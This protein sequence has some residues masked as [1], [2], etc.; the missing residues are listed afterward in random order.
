M[1]APH[2]DDESLGCG[3]TLARLPDK[4]QIHVIY[5]T[6]GSRAY[7]PV[8]PWL[9]GE[10]LDLPAIRMKEALAAAQAL[11]IPGENVHFLG[12]PDG[13][14]WSCTEQLAARLREI[15]ALI[16]PDQLMMP[17]RYDRHPDHLTVNEVARAVWRTSGLSTELFEYFV[18]YRWRLLPTG[19]VRAYIRPEHL[20]KVTID[21]GAARKQAA[22]DCYRSQTTRIYPWQ[23]RPILSR[24]VLAEACLGPEFFVKFDPTVPGPRIFRDSAAWIRLVHSLEPFLKQ[25][26]D[27][28]RALWRRV[29]LPHASDAV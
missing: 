8:L 28:A 13:Q 25:R 18:Y 14:L 27:R 23:D 19:D 3:G 21:A 12:F 4:R 24:A 26:K 16:K 6:D 22:L 7:T 1:I 11:G 9:D 5:A 17:F 2:M 20:V 15:M 10:P 29:T